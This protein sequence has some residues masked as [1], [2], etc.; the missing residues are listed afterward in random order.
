MK[1]IQSIQLDKYQSSRYELIHNNIYKDLQEN[2]YVF[3]ISFEPEADEDE[4]YPLED[5]LDQ[6]YLYV[7]DFIDEKVDTNPQ[8]VMLELAGNLINAQSAF[9]AIIGKRVYNTEYTG[10]DGKNHVKLVIE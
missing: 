3:A 4:Q 10:D 8:M 5:L 1:N 2:N 6:F 7:S 9:T